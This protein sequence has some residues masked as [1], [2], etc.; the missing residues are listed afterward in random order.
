M[1]GDIEKTGKGATREAAVI[2][3][4]EIKRMREAAVV[5][6]EQEKKDQKRIHEEQKAQQQAQA[7]ARKAKMQTMDR[8]RSKKLPPT[9]IE[10]EQN[11]R[12]EG[13]L[14]NAQHQLDEEHDDVKHMNQ[15]TLYAKVVTVRDKQLEENK[16]LEA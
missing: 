14:A 15:M 1:R 2:T 9:E 13:L 4:A 6:T 3:Q 7:K 16:E 10:V 5:T 11:K 8:D 12:A